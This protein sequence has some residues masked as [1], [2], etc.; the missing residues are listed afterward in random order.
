[1]GSDWIVV[2]GLAAGERV[3][4][5]GLQKVKNGQTVNAVEQ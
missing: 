1:M 3:I 2:S 5:E 4:T